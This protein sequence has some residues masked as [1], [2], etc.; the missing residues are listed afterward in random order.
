MYAYAS[1]DVYAGEYAAGKRHG[2]GKYLYASGDV[3]EGEYSAGRMEG[4][5]TYWLADGMAE[6]GRYRA[7]SDVGEGARWNATRTSAVRLRSGKAVGEISTDEA[8]KIAASLGLPVPAMLA[9]E[10]QQ[11]ADGA[12]V[13]GS[14]AKS[15]EDALVLVARRV[16]HG[17]GGHGGGA[18][19]NGGAA[20]AA[21]SAAP[22]QGAEL[23][24]EPTGNNGVA[25]S[26]DA[27]AGPTCHAAACE[28]HVA[29]SM[30]CAASGSD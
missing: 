20:A 1:G 16:S 3:Y 11:E 13:H 28:T 19:A 22:E 27:A 8:A 23:E 26:S 2:R 24:Q 9:E 4:R 5:G 10:A 15:G 12:P 21:E 18:P 25:P 29:T 30:P 17:G 14:Q 7:G 6:V